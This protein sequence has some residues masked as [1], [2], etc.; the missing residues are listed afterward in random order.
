MEDDQG[1]HDRPMRELVH[2]RQQVGAY[3]ATPE[4]NGASEY[5]VEDGNLER[6]QAILRAVTD[7]T[8]EWDLTTSNLY[9][10]DRMLALV[11]DPADGNSHRIEEILSLIHPDDVGGMNAALDGHLHL[12]EPY[13]PEFRLR[14]SDGE[15]RWV[16]VVG[17]AVPDAD[18]ARRASSARLR[19][20]RIP[21]PENLTFRNQS[22]ASGRYLKESATA[23]WCSLPPDRCWMPMRRHVNSLAT[24]AQT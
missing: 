11:G 12:N 21:R 1:S 4:S 24:T 19:S 8:Y 9:L 10:D 16:S 5:N 23:C 3:Q 14:M 13:R 20:S 17:E 2:M 6:L 7:G 15:Y 22:L 18:E